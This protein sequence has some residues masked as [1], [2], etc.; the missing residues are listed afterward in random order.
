MT[1]VKSGTSHKQ[2]MQN[3]LMGRY[4]REGK[5]AVFWK[6]QAR[7]SP[8]NMSMCCFC[9]FNGYMSLQCWETFTLSQENADR[10]QND[11]V[12]GT[13]TS[14]S[15]FSYVGFLATSV[16]SSLHK[17]KHELQECNTV[18]NQ[19][20]ALMWVLGPQ[21]KVVLYFSS[22]SVTFHTW[23]S[24]I[25]LHSNLHWDHLWVCWS[26]LSFNFWD[27]VQGPVFSQYTVDGCT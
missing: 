16:S 19:T 18:I 1:C 21:N 14:V 13:A 27:S 5:T 9:V 23:G 22:S 8:L 7:V 11:P 10:L 17:E 26:P 3:I 12:G 25:H 15:G 4:S 20:V 6:L 24:L 2:S